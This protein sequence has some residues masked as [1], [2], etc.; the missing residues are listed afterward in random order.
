MFLPYLLIETYKSKYFVGV[1]AVGNVKQ[2]L[3]VAVMN[4]WL[5]RSNILS[6]VIL[7]LRKLLFEKV[8]IVSP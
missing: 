4:V 8:L 1:L 5:F 7:K 2:C 6:G 3:G